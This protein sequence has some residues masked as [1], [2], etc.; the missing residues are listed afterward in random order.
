MFGSKTTSLIESGCVC[1]RSS[2]DEIVGGSSPEPCFCA[3]SFA[4]C[5][6][7]CACVAGR[8]EPPPIAYAGVAALYSEEFYALP[9]AQKPVESAIKERRPVYFTALGRYTDCP[10]LDRERLA[11][12]HEIAGPAVLEQ[13]DATTVLLPGQRLSVDRIGNLVISLEGAAHG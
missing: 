12:G 8:F 10:V 9:D 3:A 4:A 13:L 2:S 7:C 5:C 6:C 1:A 11:P